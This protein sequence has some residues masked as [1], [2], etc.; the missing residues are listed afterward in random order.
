MNFKTIDLQRG[1]GH[2]TLYYTI[3]NTHNTLLVKERLRAL[4]TVVVNFHLLM[5][6]YLYLLLIQ[7]KWIIKAMYSLVTKEMDG[8]E[9]S[10]I[11]R[12]RHQPGIAGSL[13]KLKLAYVTCLSVLQVYMIL[14]I[15]PKNIF[16]FNKI[17]WKSHIKL[18]FLLLEVYAL[19]YF[20]SRAIRHK[21]S[22]T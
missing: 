10:T 2:K 7:A 19:V 11:Y 22:Y 6:A 5:W 9:W 1:N 4:L 21:W 20:C 13:L 18:M 14:H 12:N 15:N 17:K 16:I 8:D 3:L